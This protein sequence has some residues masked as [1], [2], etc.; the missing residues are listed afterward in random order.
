MLKLAH[1][2]ALDHIIQTL[3]ATVFA[4][5]QWFG[6]PHDGARM[7]NSQAAKDMVDLAISRNEI[8]AERPENTAAIARD[9]WEQEKGFTAIVL[10][11]SGLLK[12][13]LLRF[14]LLT[15]LIVF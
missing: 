14:P 2:F 8:P 1:L 10:L 9:L 3:Y 5:E 6:V 13:N 15:F 12:V 11:F 7:Y 4:E